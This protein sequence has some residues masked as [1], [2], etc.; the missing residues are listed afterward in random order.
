M[1]R[2]KGDPR[3]LAEPRDVPERAVARMGHVDEHA[4]LL[5][6]FDQGEAERFETALFTQKGGT[7]SEVSPSVSDKIGIT[8]LVFAVPQKGHHAHAARVE[9]LE[10]AEVALDGAALFHREHGAELFF[11]DIRE[12]S[13]GE[14]PLA[15]AH[16][17]EFIAKGEGAGE[18]PLLFFE[19]GGK[20][21]HP[22]A[23]AL[24]QFPRDLK[25][26]L[27]FRESVCVQIDVFHPL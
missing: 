12:R 20:A 24:Q 3:P 11:A 15:G 21:L 26:A 4:E 25:D 16:F 13:H 19:E 17:A 2:E 18:P 10:L 9:G 5:H 6:A 8:D 22:A 7:M 1:A 14:I 23:A 27:R